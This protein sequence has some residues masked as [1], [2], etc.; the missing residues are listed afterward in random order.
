MEDRPG[1]IRPAERWGDIGHDRKQQR[2][3]TQIH[4]RKLVCKQ[5]NHVH[6]SH[7][8]VVRT[9]YLGPGISA[10]SLPS[11]LAWLQHN[12]NSIQT[13]RS[14]G[15]SPLVDAVLGALVSPESSLNRVGVSDVS[16]CALS[17]LAVF[18]NLEKCA[19]WQ[20]N[21]EHLDLA[22]LGVLP[23]LRHLVLQAGNFKELHHLLALTRL[24]CIHADVLG[25]QQ[26]A[27]TL[28]HLELDCSNLEDTHTLC[29]ST[30]SA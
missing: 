28:Q 22:P 19:F 26:L 9:L 30:C 2:Q 27:L 21:A 10:K 1:T 12:K 23:S 5:F 16:A 20:Q 4:Q 8:G 3:Q 6:A 13:F 7:P 29:L 15:G 25:V 17:S 11:L 24:E 18:T 14:E